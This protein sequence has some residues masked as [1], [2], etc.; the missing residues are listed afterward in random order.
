MAQV[1]C[2]LL[3]VTLW[4]PR[5]M[6]RSRAFRVKD[7]WWLSELTSRSSPVVTSS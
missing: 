1:Q 7:F 2:F 3:T 4:P 6:K 5:T